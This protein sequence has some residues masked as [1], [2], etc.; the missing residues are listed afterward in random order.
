L[1]EPNRRVPVGPNAELVR[2]DAPAPAGR[3]EDDG[4]ALEG[5]GVAF[6]EPFCVARLHAP[7]VNA[8]DL[9]TRR[10]PL[11]RAGEDEAKDGPGDR[12]Q[13]ERK[14]ATLHADTR[15]GLPPAPGA[16]GNGP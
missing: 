13:Q 15:G 6:E 4:H 10:D 5:A 11:R 12:D 9:D 16:C 1:G 8:V 14:R 2:S 3:D 7:D